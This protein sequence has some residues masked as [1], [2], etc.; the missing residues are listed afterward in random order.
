MKREVSL[1]KTDDAIIEPFTEG[2]VSHGPPAETVLDL[3]DAWEASLVVVGTHGRRG[4]ARVL[5]G[6]VAE[7][8]LRRSRVPVLVVRTVETDARPEDDVRP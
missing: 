2:A 1:H 5:V 3:A 6:S 8:V 7:A 4:L